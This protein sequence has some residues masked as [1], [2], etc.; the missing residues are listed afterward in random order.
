L[1][2]GI[3][4]H[5]RRVPDLLRWRSN[6]SPD[7]PA[8]KA[9]AVEW[10]YG[11]LQ[12]NVSAL[13]A[14][15]ISR[16]IRK[17]DRV[18]LL[19]YPSERFVAL[20]HSLARVG[21]VAVPLN[22]RQSTPE[23]LSQ[24]R[25]SDPSLV[26]HDR[27][28]DAKAKELGGRDGG[29]RSAS[30]Q[31][32]RVSELTA[33]P[34]LGG[35]VVGGHVDASSPHA[36]IY[37]SGS[38]GAP[39]GVELTLSNLLW[40]AIAVGFRSGASSKDTWLLCMPLFHVGGYTIIFRSVLHGSSMVL[41]PRFDPR[42]VSRSLEEDGITLVSFVPKM[43][44]DVLEV[45]GSKP[46]NPKVRSIFLGG[47][48]PPAQLL[49]AISKQ[50]LPVLL[51]YGMT[52]TCSQVAVSDALTSSRE[53]TY[54]PLLPSEV[55]VTRPGT[56][57]P[58]KFAI[59]GDV[60][61]IAVRGPAVFKGYWRKPALTRA[62]FR[63]GWF[64][65]GDLGVQ[66]RSGGHR[67]HATEGFTIL[68][69]K[70]ETIISGGEKVLPAE[71][72]AALREHAAVKDAVVIGVEDAKWGKRVVAVLEMRAEFRGGRPSAQ[73]LR[74]FLRERVGRFKVPKQYHFWSALPR[75]PAGKTLRA[76]VLSAVERGEN[77]T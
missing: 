69:R 66:Q 72:E 64:L 9:G 56:K 51:T 61:E 58:V 30:R 17:G 43:L 18:A 25:D 13:S 48:Q 39:K 46:L 19:M 55:A 34:A 36:I 77:Q 52:E 3:L 14:V 23:L 28:L 71:V 26:V 65:T 67:G 32:E 24:L 11:E 31:W 70:E 74:E 54:Y 49:A 5:W 57:G 12:E 62:R 1:S 16:G 75:T 68:G 42:R 76:A 10:S 33:E 40:N 41:H 27:A 6:I 21:A 35:H 8:L 59:P 63:A 20:A 7:A 73:E 53:Q 60:G 44:S 29:R 45:R 15:L 2:A 37:T 50:R 47:G 22:H 38:S 4:R